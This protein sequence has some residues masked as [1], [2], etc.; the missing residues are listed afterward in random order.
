[1]EKTLN[2]GLRFGFLIH[3]VSRLRRI[4]VDRAQ[5][6]GHYALA[7]VGARLFVAA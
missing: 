2:S 5:A 7:V 3:D 1:M 4:V 6:L